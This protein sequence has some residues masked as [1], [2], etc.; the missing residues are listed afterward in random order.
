MSNENNLEEVWKL[1]S[2]EELSE[3]DKALVDSLKSTID[4]EINT[5]LEKWTATEEDIMLIN[6]RKELLWEN[7]D[8]VQRLD[9]I[10]NDIN[11]SNINIEQDNQ[12]IDI[13][14][15]LQELD[16]EIET[17]LN[18]PLNN[19]QELWIDISLQNNRK[20]LWILWANILNNIKNLDDLWNITKENVNTY[21][22]IPNNVPKEN[23]GYIAEN[24]K[25]ILY[26]H[27]A[28]HPE[29][30][31]ILQKWWYSSWMSLKTTREND[32]YE[33]NLHRQIQKLQEKSLDEQVNLLVK[34]LPNNS[35]LLDLWLKTTL[36][37]K[38]DNWKKNINKTQY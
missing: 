6:V 5:I 20:W 38:D 30:K 4:N 32:K 22:N 14:L 12:E 35:D 36:N 15:I 33:A 29:R 24:L 17:A 19:L 7:D 16:N 26:T 28:I 37:Q 34:N 3:E 9:E 18:S 31:A 23:Y 8:R 2:N 27:L 1:L 11:R 13:T 10:I 25:N 21:L